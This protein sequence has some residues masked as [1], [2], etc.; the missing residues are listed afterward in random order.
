MSL[1]LVMSGDIFAS[2]MRT[3]VNPVNCVGV[4]GAGLALE[5][6]NRYPDMYLEYVRACSMGRLRLGEVR[7]FSYP[8]KNILS[9]PTKHHYSDKSTIEDI[10]RGVYDMQDRVAC[11]DLQSLAVPALGCGYGGLKWSQVEPVLTTIFEAFPCPV[12]LYAP[13]FR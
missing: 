11:W 2:R 8:E 12:E 6:K 9:F 1:T 3:L 13:I 10:V 5:F 4:M 7:L